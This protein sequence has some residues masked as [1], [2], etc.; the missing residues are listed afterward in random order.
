[1]L[2]R[3]VV[4]H[5]MPKTAEEQRSYHDWVKLQLE[6]PECHMS[7]PESDSSDK[8]LNCLRENPN[9]PKKKRVVDN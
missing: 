8:C 1:M 4:L 5:G 9:C 6:L 2:L 7:D 3:Y